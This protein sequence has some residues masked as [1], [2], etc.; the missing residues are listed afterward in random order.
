MRTIRFIPLATFAVLAGVLAHTPATSAQ[1]A[2]DAMPAAQSSAATAPA[3]DTGKARA[4]D[5]KVHG[6]W[7]IER[8]RKDGTVAERREFDNSYN[9]GRLMGY[10]LGG[11]D[12]VVDPAIIIFSNP[13]AGGLCNGL[14]GG[15]NACS[16]FA[17]STAGYGL[18]E[19][20]LGDCAPVGSCFPG[21]TTSLTPAAG[22]GY[23]AWILSAT[24]TPT[25]TGTFSYVNTRI[26]VCFTG[27]G[28]SPTTQSSSGCYKALQNTSASFTE[29]QL[30]GGPVMVTAGESLVFTVTIS[31]S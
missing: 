19:T 23:S 11:L 25:T 26:G 18:A 10:L 7:V 14:G 22:G 21:L 13:N 28:T 30:P 3:E 15:S 9:G 27:A 29:T 6:H 4:G 12:V 16:I 17:S 20:S 31:F 2:K 5:I 8:K 1:D 24:I